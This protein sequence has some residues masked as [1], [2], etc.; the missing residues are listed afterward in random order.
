MNSF[1]TEWA[2]LKSELGRLT[3]K[4]QLKEELARIATEVRKFDQ[5]LRAN[6]R[7]ETLHGRLRDMRERLID[8][9]ERVD[10]TI[11]RLIVMI[12]S[13]PRAGNARKATRRAPT[14][15]RAKAKKTARK[16]TRKAKRA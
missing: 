1:G 16:A 12:R 15:K 2:K 3:D 8:L 13:K 11:D 7:L 10:R 6:Q 4:N 14:A 5:S 9:Q